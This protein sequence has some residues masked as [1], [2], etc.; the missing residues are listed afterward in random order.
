MRSLI[1][2]LF[3][4]RIL[5]GAY[6][7]SLTGF[8]LLRWIFG[9]SLNAIA[10]LNNLLHLMLLPALILFPIALLTRRWLLVI[11][12][13]LPFR[14]VAQDTI[15]MFLRVNSPLPNDDQT[16]ISIL[17]YNILARGGTYTQTVN[18]IRDS[19]ADI[20]ALQEIGLPV[21]NIIQT[22]LS[23]AYPHMAVNPNPIATAGQA[24]LSRYP[25]TDDTYWRN[26]ELPVY[27]GHQRTLIDIDGTE[28]VIYNIHPVHPGMTGLNV[29]IRT[30]DIHLITD[31]AQVDMQTT[32]TIIVGD[33]NMTPKTADYA[34]LTDLLTDSH[35]EAGYG[36]GYTFPAE[37]YGI[38]SAFPL[39]R[40]DYLFH[41]TR[42]QALHTEVLADAGGSDHYPLFV[43]L[44]L[45]P[46][47]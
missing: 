28:I 44:A 26:E 14:V 34:H 42:W 10:L 31:R 46:N 41:D 8:L 2:I 47:N 16:V 1:I 39:A 38:F 45:Q 13:F 40:L 15:P 43:Q 9:E 6:G 19:G 3:I 33:F 17:S 12:L 24:V 37:Y 18:I 4:T 22:E 11:M 20:V 36:L 7:L 29:A 21:A 25:I 35:S 5:T 32:P 23:E 30:D 27:L